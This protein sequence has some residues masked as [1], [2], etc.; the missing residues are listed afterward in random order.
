MFRAIWWQLTTAV[1]VVS[2]RLRGARLGSGLR[3]LGLPIA[4]GDLNRVSLGDRVTF[5]SEAHATAL[6]VRSR[7]ILRILGPD[8][9]ITIGDDTG[10]SGVVICSAASVTIG[11]RCLMGAD[12]MIFDTDF[13]NHPATNRRYAQPDWPRISRPVVIGDDVFIGARAIIGK[14]A[15]I[16]HGS[17]IAAGSVVIGPIPPMSIAAGIPARVIGAVPDGNAAASIG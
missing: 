10:A 7:C 3:F 5:A 17:I 9:R 14:G 8:G 11:A 6:G 13:H 12:V 15:D 2:W 4:S 1:T 16:G